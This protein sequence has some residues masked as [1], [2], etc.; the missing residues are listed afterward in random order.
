MYAR[1]YIKFEIDSFCYLLTFSQVIDTK[2]SNYCKK[3]KSKQS[4]TIFI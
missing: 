1:K 3:S 2:T 4:Q